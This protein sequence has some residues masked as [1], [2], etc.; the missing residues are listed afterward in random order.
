MI[1]LKFNNWV[2]SVASITAPANRMDNHT[3]KV[4]VIGSVPDGWEW[5]LLLSNEDY[6]DIIPLQELSTVLTSEQLAFDGEYTLQLRAYSGS[7]VK[8]STQAVVKIGKT[9]SGDA[10]WP[11]VPT[12]FTE[13]LERAEEALEAAAEMRGAGFA[14]FDVDPDT[15]DL[16]MTYP[17]DYYGPLFVLT[18]DG[19]LEVIPNGQY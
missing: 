1:Q 5:E 7:T 14:T 6:L 9:L 18:N 16:I 12:V 4:Q 15:G 13:T 10:V 19:D 2:L 3:V 11:E 8:H 17:S